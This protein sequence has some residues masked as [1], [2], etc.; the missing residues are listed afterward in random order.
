MTNFLYFPQYFATV[1]LMFYWN[2]S[3]LVLFARW[4]HYRHLNRGLCSPSTS[5]LY[6]CNIFYFYSLDFWTN[7]II[8]PCSRLTVVRGQPQP[9]AHSKTPKNPCDHDL[10]HMTLKFNRV[11]E[12][13]E[14]H[15]R[16]KFHEAKC[17]GSWFI[18]RAYKHFCPISQ[19]WKIRKSG[20]VTL[21]FWRMTLKINRVR[22]VVKIHVRGK[23]HQAACSG[24]WVNVSTTKETPTE[25]ISHG[26]TV[27]VGKMRGFAG[28]RCSWVSSQRS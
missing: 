27:N 18:Y 9:G 14:V 28:C 15:V 11:L 1:G 13:V 23:F 7:K 12:V 6:W 25:I 2:S 20:L 8:K 26:Q 16:A 21:T 5:S 19:W 4:R 10:W 22:A 24:L 17:S 3:T